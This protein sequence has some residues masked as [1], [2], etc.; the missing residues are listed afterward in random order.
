V[1]LTEKVKTKKKRVTMTMIMR[2]TVIMMIMT[3]VM[4]VLDNQLVCI[5]GEGEVGQDKK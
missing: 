1:K 4:R 5:E 2:T 3:R